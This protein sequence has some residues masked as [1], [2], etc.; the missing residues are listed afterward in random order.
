[1]DWFGR[2]PLRGVG[3]IVTRPKGRV[4]LSQQL[5][6]LGAEVTD[7]PCIR[8]QPLPIPAEVSQRLAEQDWIVFTSATG[9]ER[10]FAHLMEAEF[11]LRALS[12]VKFAAIGERTAEV[13][14]RYALH[15]DYMPEAYHTQGLAQGLPLSGQSRV[16]LFRAQGGSPKLVSI[17]EE[18]GFSVEDIP[19]YQTTCEAAGAAQICEKI[20]CGQTRFV[21]FTSPSTVQGF[22][23]ALAGVDFAQTGLTAVCI[24]EET[25]AAARGLGLEILVSQAAT[26]ESMVACIQQKA[27]KQAGNAFLRV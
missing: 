27:A 6:A 2:L 11:D 13:L 16:L 22:T 24:G 5:C 3:V 18:R 17:L 1:L 23:H 4:T 21:T 7:F 10:F 12:R 26:A 15:A 8:T 9:A 25:A 14:T 20:T 19:A